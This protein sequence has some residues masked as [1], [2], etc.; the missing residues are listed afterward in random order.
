MDR[1]KA[2]ILFK[3]VLYCVVRVSVATNIISLYNYD[4]D[5]TETGSYTCSAVMYNSFCLHQSCLNT[6]EFDIIITNTTIHQE[7]KKK[8]ENGGIVFTCIRY[9]IKIMYLSA[10]IYLVSK[11]T[12]LTSS[13]TSFLSTC[14]VSGSHPLDTLQLCP[15]YAA[16]RT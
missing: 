1:T 5:F 3:L 9:D 6:H 13:T 16:P 10:C 7:I 15:S 12:K 11:L 8:R 2:S 14:E 4:L